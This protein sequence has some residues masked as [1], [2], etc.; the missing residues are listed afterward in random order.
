[1]IETN[2]SKQ[3]GFD[4]IDPLNVA[5]NETAERS[6]CK[7]VASTSFSDAVPIVVRRTPYNIYLFIYL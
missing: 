2:D 7:E 3:E 6:V 4:D 1:M 5:A